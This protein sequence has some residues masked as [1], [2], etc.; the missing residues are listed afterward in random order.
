[1]RRTPEI[2]HTQPL[3]HPL[4][5]SPGQG[6]KQASSVLQEHTCLQPERLGSPRVAVYC[7]RM[8]PSGSTAS[9]LPAVGSRGCWCLSGVRRFAG[10]ATVL[11]GCS[12]T[13]AQIRGRKGPE[14]WGAA[15][16]VW[17][18][19][20]QEAALVPR[21]RRR[22]VHSEGERTSRSCYQNC[23]PRRCLETREPVSSPEM[24]LVS[25]P[26]M[27]V[28]GPVSPLPRPRRKGP[29]ASAGSAEAC[30]PQPLSGVP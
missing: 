8:Q 22:A 27:L 24:F 29:G 21:T 18:L 14:L 4:D 30:S 26:E 16:R 1:M 25:F 11:G 5:G 19:T 13:A 20:C 3:L 12:H 23:I 15:A 9:C 10:T 6:G 28:V 2:P 17:G 7:A